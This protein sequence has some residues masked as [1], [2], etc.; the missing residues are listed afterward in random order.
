MELASALPAL[1][2][3]PEAGAARYRRL[4]APGGELIKLASLPG[5]PASWWMLAGTVVASRPGGLPAGPGG[6]GRLGAFRF[7]DVASRFLGPPQKTD[8]SVR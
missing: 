1:W 7:F 4:D 2:R 3:C 6:A 8:H 5:L